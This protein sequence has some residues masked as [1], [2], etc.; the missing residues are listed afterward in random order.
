MTRLVALYKPYLDVHGKMRP[1]EVN[2]GAI[3]AVDTFTARN[4]AQEL[5]KAC[6]EADA[7]NAELENNDEL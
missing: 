5:L 1:A 3:G 7:M 2:W 4:F 6:D